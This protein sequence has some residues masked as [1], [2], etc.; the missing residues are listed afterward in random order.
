M[1]VAGVTALFYLVLSKSDHRSGFFLKGR[2]F[3][4]THEVSNGDG[5]GRVRFEKDLALGES[6]IVE[7]GFV[8]RAIF[9]FLSELE[10]LL[11]DLITDL[12]HGRTT[13][14]GRPGSAFHRRFW[15]PGIA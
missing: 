10:Q 11:R 6:N 13:G 7:T 8:K 14:G 5:F 4:S 15:Q 3:R 12:L 9:Q 1:G 2:H